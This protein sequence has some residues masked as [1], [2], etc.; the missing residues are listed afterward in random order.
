MREIIGLII[1]VIYGVFWLLNHVAKQAAEK[2][3]LVN[4][5]RQRELVTV[6]QQQQADA[7]RAAPKK[8]YR[9]IEQMRD[10]N[11]EI[12]GAFV[13]AET[14]SHSRRKRET[15]FDAPV[16]KP[17]ATFTTL[18]PMSEDNPVAQGIFAMMTT[19]QTMQQA[20]I[21]SEIYNRPKYD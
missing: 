19:P 17:A 21:L 16:G 12:I 10:K 5:E 20:V 14:V 11:D 18:K 6:R 4:A 7:G 13:T 15:A 9:E 2:Q 3:K 8:N 1:F